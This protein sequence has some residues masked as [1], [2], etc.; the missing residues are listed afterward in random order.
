MSSGL[1]LEGVSQAE[2]RRGWIADD[3][4]DDGLLALSFCL[5]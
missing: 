5:G 1:R 3:P 4:G 2:E